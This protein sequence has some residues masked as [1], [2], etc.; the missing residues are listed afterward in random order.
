[1]VCYP[2][3]HKLQKKFEKIKNFSYIARKTMIYKDTWNLT[4]NETQQ[5]IVKEALD[6][7]KFPWELIK[8]PNKPVE[9]GWRDLN[10]GKYLKNAK[11]HEGH[12]PEKQRPAVNDFETLEGSIEGR[13]YVMGIFY[14][15]TANIYVDNLLQYYPSYAKT[16]VSAEIAHAVDEF[17]PLSNKQREEIMALLHP[18]GKDNHTW[19][20]K[21]DYGAEYYSLVGETFMILFTKAYSDTPFEGAEDF[22]HDGHNVKPEDV[23]RIIGVERTDYVPPAP[24][25]EPVPPTFPDDVKDV[26][27]PVKEPEI[28]PEYPKEPVKEPE[29]TS[30]PY[31][32]RVGTKIYHDKHHNMKGPYK[33][34]NTV[35]EAIELGLKPCKT[36]KPK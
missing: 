9:I 2:I 10:I 13:K 28:V 11:L 8:V 30:G 33:F 4:G 35:D 27:E 36:C 32:T 21:Q 3:F 25:E 6:A 5:A 1:L 31:F 24:K 7:I 14:P 15:S 17:L 22:V 20:E 34:F 16:T 26:P 18:D 12:H 23:R 19:W 29:L